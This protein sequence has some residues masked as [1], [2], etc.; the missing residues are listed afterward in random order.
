MCYHAWPYMSSGN[1]SSESY[2]YRASALPTDTCPQLLT[3]QL[4]LQPQDV[5][6][7]LH[8]LIY[9]SLCEPMYAWC[10]WRSEDSL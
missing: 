1:S 2:T 8:L 4:S 7:K 10:V 6:L 5:I 3:A 9:F